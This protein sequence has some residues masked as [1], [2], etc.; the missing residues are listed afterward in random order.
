M[1]ILGFSKNGEMIKIEDLKDK[2]GYVWY[3]LASSVKAFA[4]KMAIGSEVDLKVEEK[5][6]EDT[7]VYITKS[8]GSQPMAGSSASELKCEDCGAALKD[9]K[10]KTCYTCSMER[11]K[12]EEASPEGQAKQSSIERQCCLKAASN[13][14][15]T[16]MQGQLDVDTLGEAICKLFDKLYTKLMS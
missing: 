11:R 6:G 14:V 1:K 3:F 9:N 13:A 7:V 5:N 8:G 15:A 2:K 10:Y 12:K 16:A 4:T